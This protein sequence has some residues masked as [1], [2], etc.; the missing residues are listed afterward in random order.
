MEWLLERDGRLREVVSY[1]IW[2]VLFSL[3]GRNNK[4]ER[5]YMY[6]NNVPN[7]KSAY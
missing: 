2:E 7:Y 1:F 3:T 5:L 4:R 6:K